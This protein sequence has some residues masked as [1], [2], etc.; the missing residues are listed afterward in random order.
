MYGHSG[1]LT[2]ASWSSSRQAPSRS[3][4]LARRP[5]TRQIA[6][7][8]PASASWTPRSASCAQQRSACRCRRD[9]L[10]QTHLD[11][12]QELHRASPYT[13]ASGAHSVLERIHPLATVTFESTTRIH[14]RAPRPAVDHLNL[15]VDDGEFLVLVGPSGCGKTTSLRMLAGLEDVD[16][17]P[18][19]I[20]GEDV[21]NLAP[22]RPRHRDGVPELRAL[23]AHDR[24]RE[25]GLRAEDRA[26][27]QGG[28]QGA[29]AGGRQ[30]PRPRGLPRPPAGRSSRAASAS[31]WRWGARSCASRASS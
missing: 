9:R 21:V 28:D 13:L 26:A 23:P 14:P 20:D 1:R 7:S 4:R 5:G 12:H 10:G 30:D 17:G 27:R 3:P 18:I 25:H 16:A 24:R 22:R 19:Q 8:M 31:A 2:S 15:D 11:L 29:R 6:R